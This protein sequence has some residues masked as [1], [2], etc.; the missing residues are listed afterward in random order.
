MMQHVCKYKS[1]PGLQMWLSPGNASLV[2][3]DGT[4]CCRFAA[5]SHTAIADR[6]QAS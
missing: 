3:A 2:L 4:D 5:H 1:Q 6:L